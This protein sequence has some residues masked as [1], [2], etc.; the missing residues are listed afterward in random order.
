MKEIARLRE[1]TFRAVGEGTQLETDSDEYDD[2][3]EHL[4]V[5]DAEKQAIAGAYRIGF[6]DVLLDNR[7]FEGFY[8]YTLFEF[9]RRLNDVLRQ[10]IE[11]GRS[12]VVPG[13]QRRSQTLL[14]LWRGILHVLLRNPSYR[15][16]MG[17]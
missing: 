1:V 5:W 7:G 12:F 13:Y 15:Y 17:P 4:F 3:Y 14:L 11:L 8:T 9:S 16:L 6:G 2:L 10:S